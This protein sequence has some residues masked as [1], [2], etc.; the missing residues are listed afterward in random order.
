MTVTII[1][2]GKIKEDYLKAACAEYEKRLSGYCRFVSETVE[3][4]RLPDIPSDAEINAALE[5]EG[6]KILSKLPR[7]AYRVAMCVEGEEKSSMQLASLMEKLAVNGYGST[8]F[9][10][11][12]S[13][14]LSEK[15][16]RASNARLSLSKM[17]FPHQL[18]RVMLTEQIYRSYTIINNNRY[19]K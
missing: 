10:I 18:L 12:G 14:G 8:V 1:S 4:E 11:G 3:P 9:M 5:K 15:V 13:Y 6:E 2:V 17:T 16:K 7:S 19:H